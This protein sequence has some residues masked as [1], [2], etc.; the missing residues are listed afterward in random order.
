MLAD[1]IVCV[2]RSSD[3]SVAP[4]IGLASSAAGG[5]RGIGNWEHAGNEAVA[6]CIVASRDSAVFDGGSSANKQQQQQQRFHH[7]FPNEH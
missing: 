1:G 3:E 4:R 2:A 7:A 5:G 6:N